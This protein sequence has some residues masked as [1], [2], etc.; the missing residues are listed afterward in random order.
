M[1]N[2]SALASLPVPDY[3]AALY[4]V[5]GGALIFVGIG[6]CLCCWLRGG[7]GSQRRQHRRLNE[8]DIT[9]RARSKKLSMKPSARAVDRVVEQDQ[10]AED[11]VDEEPQEMQPERGQKPRSRAAAV[12]WDSDRMRTQ[13]MRTQ[14]KR[15]RPQ[16]VSGIDWDSEL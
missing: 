11:L 6:L 2:V 3:G 7:R 5:V 12:N 4:G 15:R 14:E 13:P 1:I 9:P 16:R 8:A 10:E